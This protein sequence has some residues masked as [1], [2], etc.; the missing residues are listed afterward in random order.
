MRKG[1]QVLHKEL[2]DVIGTLT[3]T[4]DAQDAALTF[5]RD[6]AALEAEQGRL[7]SETTSLLLFSDAAER[8]AKAKQK[9]GK[10]AAVDTVV[11]GEANPATSGDR[12][13]AT[14]KFV[15]GNRAARGNPW[16]RRLCQMRQ[17]FAEALSA[18]D[19]ARLARSLHADALEGDT[20]AAALLLSYCIGKPTAAPDPDRLDLEELLL[21]L[22]GPQR[23]ELLRACLSG[24][25]AGEAAEYLRK[26][27]GL[28]SAADQIT[29]DSAVREMAAAESGKKRRK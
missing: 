2:D 3:A 9:K 13:A 14:G 23:A 27:I 18:D 19:L 24:V 17:A 7:K 4:L 11:N 12:D 6:M 5:S 21:L 29:G 20:A 1:N 15:P 28:Q 22:E 25:A 16:N 26:A 10:P 8:K